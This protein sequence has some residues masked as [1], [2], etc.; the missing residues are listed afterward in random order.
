MQQKAILQLVRQNRELAFRQL[1]LSCYPKV[2]RMIQQMG[3][4]Q[5]DAQDV[6][7]DSLIVLY[8]KVVQGKTTQ[9]EQVESY[10]QGIARHLWL[11]KSRQ[12]QRMPLDSLEEVAVPADFYPTEKIQLRLSR[13][14]EKAGKKCMALLQAFYYHQQ[15]LS[16]IATQF[17]YS[18][19]RSAT[20]QKFKCLQKV[21]EVV[22]TKANAYETIVE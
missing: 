9:I 21:R 19:T 20:V 13:Y 2:A 15:S 1:Y 3:G 22:K 10:L 5:A 7:Q 8:E 17:G 14:L 18:N 4:Q 12:Q 16:E 6:F 11:Q